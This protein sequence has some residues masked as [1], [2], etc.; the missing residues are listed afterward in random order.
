MHSTS[1][2]VTNFFDGRT[3]DGAARDTELDV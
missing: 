1:S 2:V 3:R